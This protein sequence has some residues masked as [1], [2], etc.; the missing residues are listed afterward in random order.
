MM[1]QQFY[2]QEKTVQTK[3][4]LSQGC[5]I[6]RVNSIKKQIKNT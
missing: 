3:E 2:I 5:L 1:I 4:N 6:K